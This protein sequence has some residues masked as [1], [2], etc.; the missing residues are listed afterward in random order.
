MSFF[1]NRNNNITGAQLL[2]GF[3]FDPNYGSSAAFST[4]SS[5]IGYSDKVA[6]ITPLGINNVVGDYSLNFSLRKQDTQDLI[7]FY[8]LQSGTGVI[9]LVDNSSIYKTLSGVINS[10]DSLSSENNDRFNIGLKFSVERNSSV[11]NWSGQSFVNYQFQRWETGVSYKSYDCVYFEN[12]QEEPINNFFYCLSDHDSLLVNNPLSTGQKWTTNLFIDPNDQFSIQQTPSVPTNDFKGSFLQRINDQKNVHSLDKIEIAYKN[13]SDKK[14]KSLLHFLES[15]AGSKKFSYSFPQIY[16]R[17]KVF[18]APQ[19][20]HQ[21]NFKDSNNLKITVSE[22]PLG[23]LFSG[24]PMA[25]FVQ[26]SGYSSIAFSYSGSDRMFFD[27]GNGKELLSGSNKVLTW[28]DDTAKRGLKLWG[29]FSSLEATG[30]GLISSKFGTSRGLSNLYLGNNNLSGIKLNDALDLQRL[31]CQNNRLANL[32]LGNKTGLSY[33]DCSNNGINYLNIGGTSLTGLYCQN[34]A[35]STLYVDSCVSGLD[36]NRLNS[37]IA[38]FSGNSGISQSLLR[39]VS[40]LTG[41]GWSIGYEYIPP[42]GE[43][44]DNFPSVSPS[45]PIGGLVYVS[46]DDSHAGACA[47][48]ETIMCVTDSVFNTSTKFH[49]PNENDIAQY[50]VGQQFYVQSDNNSITVLK[51]CCGLAEY[52]S[53]PTSCGYSPSYETGISTSPSNTLG[54]APCATIGISASM[55]STIFQISTSL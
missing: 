23:I 47:L 14:I 21:W 3:S 12:D 32:E 43:T 16:D 25:S 39:E 51:T 7:N 29:R 48:L 4:K 13:I 44:P 35:L 19:W 34:N 40:S 8:E 45:F 22:D 15:R 46:V 24:A 55:F 10:I 54:S 36:I 49:F 30:Q 9:A 18:F 27:T 11:L 31:E 2:T 53:G 6:N 1:Y 52:V 17:P 50:S 20:D 38:N 26:E 41:K 5:Y 28:P 37:G 33:L 42:P